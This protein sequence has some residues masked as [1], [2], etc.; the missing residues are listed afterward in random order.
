MV[1]ATLYWIKVATVQI[2]FSL[3]KWEFWAELVF[4]VGSN[5]ILLLIYG[6]DSGGFPYLRAFW[7]FLIDHIDLF[8]VFI[9]IHVAKKL[10]RRICLC[11]RAKVL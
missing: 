6:K 4:L 8:N 1:L 11:L 9:D 7:F 2:F 3:K 10:P 5:V